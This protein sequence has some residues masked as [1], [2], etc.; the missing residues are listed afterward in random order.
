MGTKEGIL[1]GW[2][3]RFLV[4]DAERS[5]PWSLILCAGLFGLDRA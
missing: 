3:I 2:E 1:D 4:I 5:S